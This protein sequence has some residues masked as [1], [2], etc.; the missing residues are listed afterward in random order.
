[1]PSGF[2]RAV[3]TVEVT[4][5]DLDK[6]GQVLGAAAGAGANQMFG[7]AFEIEDPAPLEAEARKKA[8]ADARTRAERL[9][10]LGGVKLGPPVSISEAGGGM[11][12]PGPMVMRAEVGQ[13]P[14][15]RGELTVVATVQV[16]YSIAGAR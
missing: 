2:Y 11:P 9:A 8:M 16:V 3:N 5:R 12:V 7:I 10:E 1:M 4:I 15:E 14:I 13:V 6:A